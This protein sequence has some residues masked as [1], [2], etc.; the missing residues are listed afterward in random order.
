MEIEDH[1]STIETLEKLA[2][3]YRIKGA[4]M[5]AERLE[6]QAELLKVCLVLKVV[7]K[8]YVKIDNYCYLYTDICNAHVLLWVCYWHRVM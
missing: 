1:E 6:Q 5:A 2:K 8:D 4:T 7:C 3:D